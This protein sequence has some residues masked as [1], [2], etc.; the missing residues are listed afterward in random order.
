MATLT[1]RGANATTPAK[2]PGIQTSRIEDP[3]VRQAIDALRES[4]EVRLGSRGDKFE[5]AV[6]FRE[7]DP[8][9]ADIQRRLV[10]LEQAL[11]STDGASASTT[12]PASSSGL[13]TVRNELAAAIS[14]Y[15]R[16]DAAIQQQLSGDRA[17]IDGGLEYLRSLIGDGLALVREEVNVLRG[18]VNAATRAAAISLSSANVFTAGQVVDEVTL[19]DGA[20]VTIDADV[21]NNFQLTLGGNR[22]IANPTN[23]RKGGVINL[24]LRQDGTGSR[25]VTWGSKWDFGAAGAPVLSTGA[26]KVDFVSAYYNA[27]ADKLLAAFRKSA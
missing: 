11:G 7:F 17:A 24:V 9:V 2:M 6:T 4:V 1:R 23:M 27:T 15:K 22:T 26:N 8:Q 10:A 14:D 18:L 19:T 16:T 3:N 13:A 20:T 12:T 21:S 25:T 5:R